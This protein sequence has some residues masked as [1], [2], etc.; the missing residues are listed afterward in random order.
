MATVAGPDGT[1]LYVDRTGGKR[2]EKGPFHVVYADGDRSTRWG[3]LCANCGTLD[4]AVDT[5]GR[6]QC[7]ECSNRTKAEEWDAAHE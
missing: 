4:N 5:M 6:V 2:G 3:S 1:D 7:N